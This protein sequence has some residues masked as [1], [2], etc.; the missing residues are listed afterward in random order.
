VQLVQPKKLITWIWENETMGLS[1]AE[2][3]VPHYDAGA[4][5]RRNQPRKLAKEMEGHR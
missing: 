5:A 2:P 3:D 1:H 4:A